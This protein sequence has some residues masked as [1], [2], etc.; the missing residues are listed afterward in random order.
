MRARRWIVVGTALLVS[1]LTAVLGSLVGWWHLGPGASAAA[2]CLVMILLAASV[3]RQARLLSDV[4]AAASARSRVR[5]DTIVDNAAD[6]ILVVDDRGLVT[7]VSRSV[8][9][10]FGV[11]PEFLVGHSMVGM[12]AATGHPVGRDDIVD[13]LRMHARAGEPRI[14]QRFLRTCG[15]AVDLEFVIVDMI[16]DEEVQGIVISGRDVTAQREVEAQLAHRATHD[17]LTGLA[18]RDLFLQQCERALESEPWQASD[19]GE[20]PVAGVAVLYVDL[21]GFKSVNDSVGHAAGDELLRA[22]AARLET[23]LGPDGLVARLGGDEFAVLLEDVPDARFAVSLA[24]RILDAVREPVHTARVSMSVAASIGIAHASSPVDVDGLIRNADLAMYAAKRLGK[25][26]YDVFDERMNREALDAMQFRVEL[27]R[28]VVDEQ[29]TLR[30]LPVAHAT[31]GRLAGAEAQ[32]VWEHPE[33]G[34]LPLDAFLPAAEEAGL[35]AGLARLIL[36]HATADC[37]AWNQARPAEPLWVTVGLSASQLLD[38]SLV[39]FVGAALAHAGLEPG[40]LVIEMNETALIEASDSLVDVARR[41]SELGVSLAL[42]DFGAGHTSL[43]SLPRFPVDGFI[44]VR[45]V[46]DAVASQEILEAS[47]N[48][49]VLQV[50]ARDHRAVDSRTRFGAAAR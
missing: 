18:N 5:L 27:G 6:L 14:Q 28:A 16:D 3:P 7:Y 43:G 8:R 24:E 45:F 19:S 31:T 2:I 36:E 40:L 33:R 17:A 32:L 23:C 26:R 29:M 50:D 48:E 10:Y 37:V 9:T 35:G 42:D 49:L 34:L 25:G 47:R 21:D 4:E 11:G 30:Y 46:G 39:D 13:W 38:P 41:L 15:L 20:S 22:I 44:Q 1:P 12:L